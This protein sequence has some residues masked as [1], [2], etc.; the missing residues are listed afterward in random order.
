MGTKP[1]KQSAEKFV[2]D[3]RRKARKLYSSEQKILIV[4]E[5]LRG[6]LSVAEICRKYG[7]AESMFY[8]WNKE[9]M[10]AGKKRLAGDTT[11][12]ATSDEVSDL[13]KE[14]QRLK[15]MV[16]DLMLRYDIVKKSLTIL[17]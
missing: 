8:K 2:K 9:F 3:I 4:M 6:E 1:Q 7:I 5:A 15:E 17:E 16:A 11:R 10:E 14:N 12:E 13:R